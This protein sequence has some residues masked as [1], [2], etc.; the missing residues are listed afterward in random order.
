MEKKASLPSELTSHFSRSE[1]ELQK[2]IHD[3][4]SGLGALNQALELMCE[5]GKTDAK[6]VEQIAPLSF[7]KIQSLME[8]WEQL[9]PQLK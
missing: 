8:I 9:R 1:K 7:K 2:L 6:L 3:M 5:E 4:N